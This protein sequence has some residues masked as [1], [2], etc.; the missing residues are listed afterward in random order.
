MSGYFIT[1]LKHGLLFRCDSISRWLGV[2]ES[3]WFS[4]LKSWYIAKHKC[5]LNAHC[6]MGEQVSLC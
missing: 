2:W 5:T 4:N 3:V 6:T 1:C